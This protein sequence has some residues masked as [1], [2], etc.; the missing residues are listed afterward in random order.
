MPDRSP[1]ELGRSA[2]VNITTIAG[3]AHLL[4]LPELDLANEKRV[5]Y[6]ACISNACEALAR[7]IDEALLVLTR[8]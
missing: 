6:A 5:E 3:F 7:D 8:D 4:S 2:R 1:H